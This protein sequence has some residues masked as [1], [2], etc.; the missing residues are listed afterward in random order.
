MKEHT[1]NGHTITKLLLL[2]IVPFKKH[3]TNEHNITGHMENSFLENIN[4]QI[5]HSKLPDKTFKITK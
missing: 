5:K 1:I 3:T 4:Y 2:I